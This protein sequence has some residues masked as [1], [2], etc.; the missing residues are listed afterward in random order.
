MTGA[1]L[2]APAEA[3]W[4]VVTNYEQLQDFIPNI[5]VCF[6][7]ISRWLPKLYFLFL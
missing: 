4:R 1:H 2:Q 5:A 6:H 7:K 3:I